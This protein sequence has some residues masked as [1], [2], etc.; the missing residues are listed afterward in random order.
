MA[1]NTEKR[2]FTR[3]AFPGRLTVTCAAG[4]SAG[5]LRDISLKGVLMTRP[6]EWQHCP[7]SGERVD[8]SLELESGIIIDAHGTTVHVG[9]EVIGFEFTKL[10]VESAAHLRR[11][12]ELNLGDGELLEREFDALLEANEGH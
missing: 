7:Q 8:L 9:A 11:L 3:I 10:P 5:D 6:P 2:R 12:V 4:T 1:E